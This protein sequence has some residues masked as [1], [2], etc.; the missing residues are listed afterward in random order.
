MT[1]QYNTL[2]TIIGQINGLKDTLQGTGTKK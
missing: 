2:S 1:N